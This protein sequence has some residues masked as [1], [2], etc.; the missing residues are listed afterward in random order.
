MNAMNTTNVSVLFPVADEYG[1]ICAQ[2]AALKIKQ[3]E[4]KKKIIGSGV[5]ELEGNLFRISVSTCEVETLDMEAVRAKLSVQ[6][7][8]AHTNRVERTTVRCVSRVG[9]ARKAA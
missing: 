8:T 9:K 3:D 1:E 7:I 5:R 6:F 4:L 2:I